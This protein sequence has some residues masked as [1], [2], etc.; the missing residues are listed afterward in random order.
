MTA[1]SKGGSCTNLDESQ[2][3][4]ECRYFLRFRPDSFRR[5]IL[6]KS[7]P[8][9]YG[10]II[11]NDIYIFGKRS[12]A[13]IK[14]RRELKTIKLKILL[15]RDVSGFELWKKEFED[16]LP[17]A[18]YVWTRIAAELG[19]ELPNH[20]A[21]SSI[22]AAINI[23][24]RDHQ[25]LRLLPVAKRRC[26]YRSGGAKLEVSRITLG[27][28]VFYTVQFESADLDAAK[29]LRDKLSGHT[30][31]KDKNYIGASLEYLSTR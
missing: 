23:L 15:E 28:D 25:Y 8:D 10:P 3:L 19:V 13:N 29:T 22:E 7:Y 12:S 14:L 4:W 16:K 27:H 18:E 26:F 20:A 30:L 17:A 9:R 1:A 24:G 21:L 2:V 31:G 6:E 11:N 5:K